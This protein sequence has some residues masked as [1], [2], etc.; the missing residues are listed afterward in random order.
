MKKLLLF[1]AIFGMLLFT[2]PTQAQE[3]PKQ[4]IKQRIL[5]IRLAKLRA[6]KVVVNTWTINT[7]SIN[8]PVIPIV[9][10][11]TGTNKE[12]YEK[13][14]DHIYDIERVLYKIQRDSMY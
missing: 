6:K 11:F 1:L 10:T 3:A 7:G 5:Q 8:C 12:V 14:R 13:A 9:T 4:T 2:I